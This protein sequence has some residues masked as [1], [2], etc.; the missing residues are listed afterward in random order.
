MAPDFFTGGSGDP[1]ATPGRPKSVDKAKKARRERDAMDS[2]E[3]GFAQR[4]AV[5]ERSRKD[6]R[7][8]RLELARAVKA[9]TEARL[10]ARRQQRYYE[11]P[12]YYAPRE[13]HSPRTPRPY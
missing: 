4:V 1:F 7:R 10:S 13:R 3:E 6:S 8:E 11:Q 5:L 9:N 2:R 12:R